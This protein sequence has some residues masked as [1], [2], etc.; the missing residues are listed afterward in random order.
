VA[1]STVSVDLSGPQ[2]AV[3]ALSLG[4]TDTT[5][6][7]G[8][9]GFAGN[10]V[11]LNSGTF[12]TGTTEAFKFNAVVNGT[13][14]TATVTVNGGTNGISGPDVI[15]QLN[16]GLGSAQ[17]GSIVASQ[18]SAGQLTFSSTNAFNVQDLST[19]TSTLITGSGTTTA[20][21]ETNYV[22]TGNTANTPVTA[23]ATETLTFQANGQTV[24]VTLTGA[25]EATVTGT[26]NAINA[27]TSQ[28]G[29]SAVV[30]T[31]GTGIDFQSNNT[32]Q[33]SDSVGATGL[34]GVA[35]N[36]IESPTT[37]PNLAATLTGNAD[38]AITAINTA[39]LQL[40]LTQGIVGAG[41][42]TLNYAINLAQSQITNF[43]S[44]E[45]QIKD[46]D[47]AQQAANLSKSQVLTQ[48]AVAALAQANAEPQAVL[49]L[50][51]G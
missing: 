49:K 33:V 28:Y 4:L 37:D 46:A 50:L 20:N 47:V 25:Q 45:S 48:T 31:A 17:L 14:V 36:T 21:N 51:Q 12:L 15:A 44:S 30:N 42:N 43:S 7:G 19:N 40:G 18:N 5:V 39:I 2:N 8:G 34:L 26:A 38:A 32:F 41:E 11:N 6:L 35:A 9:T 24:S 22:Y 27:T 13:A 1:D 23:P 29:I 16:Q 10:T 3:D